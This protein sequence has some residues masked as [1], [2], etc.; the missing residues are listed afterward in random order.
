MNSDSPFLTIPIMARVAQD[1]QLLSA[2]PALLRLQLLA[3]G[4]AD[5]ILA[6]PELLRLAVLSIQTGIV[7][8]QRV[9]VAEK[10]HD[11]ALWVKAAP[12]ADQCE[13]TVLGWQERP[14]PDDSAQRDSFDVG[15]GGNEANRLVLDANFLVIAGPDWMPAPKTGHHFATLMDVQLTQHGSHPLI[16]LLAMR[17][18]ITDFRVC[19]LDTGLSYVLNLTPSWND[20]EFFGFIGSL[21]PAPSPVE[22]HSGDSAY[23]S[24]LDFGAQIAPVLKQP[25]SRIIA[26]AETIRAKL[27]GPLRENYASYAQ[28]IANAARHL[29]E[30]VSDM[31]DLSAIDQPGF[32]VARDTVE[33]GDIA[34]RVG[35]LLALKASDSQIGITM[36]SEN[37]QVEAIAEFRRVL[38]IGLNLVGNAI[39]YAPNGTRITIETKRDGHEAILRVNDQGQGIN[40][41][42]RERVFEKFERLGLTGDGGSGLGLYISRRLARAM[43][44]E[45]LV[46]NAQGGGACFE[47][48][49]PG[50]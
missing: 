12:V 21:D 42:D 3:G 10:A 6:L 32:V 48:R 31:E 26:N 24:T 13:L 7:L 16:D 18:E 36:P 28:D 39:R 35:G 34:R 29:N 17:E 46:R 9:S 33:L 4:T 43:G 22:V 8:E 44:G 1:G 23:S 19:S 27:N 20:N 2:D 30:L 15:D 11:I 50:A 25:L 40:A 45:L 37:E 49:L 41:E 5:G 14:M 38:Q 47:L